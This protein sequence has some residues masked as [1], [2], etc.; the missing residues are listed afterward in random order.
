VLLETEQPGQAEPVAVEP[1]HLAEA[2]GRA[3]DA[4]LTGGQL[5]GP[6]QPQV[7]AVINLG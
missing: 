4:D 7:N 6:G 3:G 5:L 1:D 2:V